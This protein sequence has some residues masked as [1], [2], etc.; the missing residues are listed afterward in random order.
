M[1]SN[2]EQRR[3]GATT[4][5]AAWWRRRVSRRHVMIGLGV[6]LAFD[7]VFYVFAVAPLGA[8]EQEQRIFVSTLQDQIERKTD[9]VEKLKTVVGKVE[10]ARVD[11]E[12]LTT[13]ILMTR[14]TTYSTLLAELIAAANDAGIEARERNYDLDPI[15]GAEQYGAITV[16]GTFRGE[17]ENLVRLLNRLDRSER[18]LIIGALGA[19]PRSDS[20]DLQISLSIDT[21]IQGL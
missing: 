16:T 12:A 2:S 20:N 18:F 7:V 1:T 5:G 6:L 4:R 11:G 10:T 14:R 15:D 8:R 21:F 19:V 3:P 13:E 17:Y 9:E